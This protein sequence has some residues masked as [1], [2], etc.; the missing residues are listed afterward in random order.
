MVE[1]LAG[2]LVGAAVADKMGSKNWGNLV[3][4]IDPALL[5]DAEAIRARTQA[6]GGVEG[7]GQGGRAAAR[8]G[9]A[10]RSSRKCPRA[11]CLAFPPHRTPP[12]PTT[13][14]HQPPHPTPP[15]PTNHPTPPTTPPHPTPPTTPQP[16]H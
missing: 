13:P 12:H 11:Y 4:A 7:W 14:P 9:G 1:L 16:T 3:I 2:P 15:H 5:G 10:A 8:K 6:R